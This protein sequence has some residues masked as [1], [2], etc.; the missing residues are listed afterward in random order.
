MVEALRARVAGVLRVGE[1]EVREERALT[2]L[3]LDSLAAV[4]LQHALEVGGVEVAIDELLDGMTFGELVERLERQ[5]KAKEEKALGEEDLRGARDG[6][7]TSDLVTHGQ[8]ALWFLERVAPG[9][10][11]YH[12]AAAARVRG[13]LDAAALRRAF[14]A[15]VARH[16]A[17]RTVYPEVEGEPRAWVLAEGGLDFAEED[18]AGWSDGQALAWLGAEAY[19]AFDLER[20]PVVRVRL[21]QRDSGEPMLLFAVHHIAADFWSLAVALRDLG[22]LYRAERSGTRAGLPPAP[23]FQAQA[24]REAARLAGDMEEAWR[25][26]RET[27][28]GELPVLDLPADRPRPPAQT[29]RGGAVALRLSRGQIDAFR[30]AARRAETTLFTQ[31]F[32]VFSALLS[33]VTGQRDLVLGTPTSGRDGAGGA[34]LAA[35]VGYF[36]NPVPLRLDLSGDPTF[37]ELF[38]RVRRAVLGAFA[39]AALPFPLLAERL[40]PARD[41][42]RTPIFQ[43]MLTLLSGERLGQPGLAGFALSEPAEP[44]ALGDLTLEPL[45]LPERR[46]Q[47]GLALNLAELS[48]G[49]LAVFEHDADL[50]DRTTIARLA[51]WWERLAAGA[52]ADPALPLSA[53]PLLAPAER[54]QLAVEWNDTEPAPAPPALAHDLVFAQAARTPDAVAVAFSSPTDAGEARLTYAELAARAAALA[55]RLRAR[56]I[57]AERP[58]ALCLPRDAEMVVAVLAILAAGGAYLPLDSALPDGRLA[59]VLAEARP[60]LLL[61]RASLA[62][63]LGAFAGCAVATLEELAAGGDPTALVSPAPGD[64]SPASLAYLIYTSGSTGVPK[65][66]AVTHR[67]AVARLRWDGEILSAADLAGLLAGTSAG[68]DISVFELLA[69]LA[70]GGR[71]IVAADTLA[72]PRLPCAGEVTLVSTVPQ[73]LAELVGGGGLPASVRAVTVGGEALP[74][75][76]AQTVLEAVRRSGAARLLNLYGPSEDTIDSTCASIADGGEGAPPIGRPIAGTRAHLLDADGALA[77]LGAVGEIHLG[78]AG[79][80]RGYLHRPDLTAESFRPDP[81]GVDATGARLYATGDLARRRPGGELEYLGRRD[82]QVKVRGVRIELAEVEAALAAHPAVRGAAVVAARAPGSRPGSQE[83]RLV[84][85]VALD[86][87]QPPASPSDLRAF[88]RARLAEPMIPAGLVLLPELPRTPNGKIDRLALARRGWSPEASGGGAPRGP[89]AFL[90]AGLWSEMLGLPAEDLGEA[91]DFFALGGHSLAAVRLASRVRERFGVEVPLASLLAAPTLGGVAASVDRALAGGAPPPPS[92]PVARAAGGAAPLTPAQRRLWFLARL[93]PESAAYHLPAGVRLAGPLDVPALA[94][95][96][97]EI[98]RRHEALRTAIDTGDAGDAGD[99]IDADDTRSDP[100]VDSPSDPIARVLPAG[101]LTL[102]LADLGGLG[103]EPARRELTRLARDEARRPFDLARGPL[104]RFRLL[105]LG[106]AEHAL[107][108]TFHHLVSDGASLAIFQR[109]LGSLYAAFA[110]G[111]PSP[112]AE[113]AA[114]PGDY[115]LWRAQWAAR[116]EAEETA[117]ARFRERLAGAPRELPLPFDRAPRASGD[118]GAAMRAGLAERALSPAAAAALSGLAR[119]AGAT[120][121]MVLAAAASAL[122]G[123]FCGVDDLVL[124]TPVDERRRPELAGTFGLLVNTVPLRVELAGD[125][126]AGEL[127]GRLRREVL[128]A[129][130]HQD[131]PFERL[132]EELAPGRGSGRMPLVQATVT[133][134]PPPLAADLP[135]LAL[136]LLPR[137]PTEAKLDLAISLTEPG[138]GPGAAWNASIEYPAAR[139]DRTTIARLLSGLDA[140]LA[141]MAESGARLSALSPLSPA[142]RQQAHR[143]W[144]DTDPNRDRG[145]LA[146]SFLA[147]ARRQPEAPAVACGGIEISYGELARRAAAVALRLRQLDVGPEAVVGLATERSAERIVGLL[148]IVLAG[149]AYLPLDPAY[150]DERLALMVADAGARAVVAHGGLWREAIA[151]GVAVVEVTGLGEAA[152]A[153]DLAAFSPPPVVAESLACI[154]YT[155]GSTGRPKG[156]AV[157]Q[158]AVLRLVEGADYVRLSPADRVAHLSTLSFD[159]ASFEIWGALLSGARLTMPPAGALS[160]LSIEA[161]GRFVRESGTTVLWLTAGLFRQVVEGGLDDLQGVRQL[162]AG[163]DALSAPHVERALRALPGCRLIDGYGPTENGTFSCCHGMAGPQRFAG[164]VPIGR[165]IAGSRAAVL[166]AGLAEVPIGG[167]G[168]LCVGGEGLARGYWRDPART[169]ERFVPDPAGGEPGARLYRT[170]DRARSLPDG[171]LDFLGRLDRQV[172]VRGF[173]VE[174]GEV[175]AALAAHPEV[176]GAAVEALADPA[177]ERRLVAYVVGDGE[178]ARP[179]TAAPALR[180]F[181]RA[182]L[183]EHAVPSLFVPL[184]ELPLTPQGKVDRRALPAPEAAVAS[185]SIA[186]AATPPAN[187]IAELIATVF[188]EVLGVERVGEGDDFFALGGH[189]L[190]ATRAVSRLSAA[191]GVE[192][193]LADLFAAP[194]PAALAARLAGAGRAAAPPIAR[195]GS[196]GEAPLSFSQERL[197]FL[198]QLQPGSPLY[199]IFGAVRLSGELDVAALAAA[200]AEIVRRHEALRT[201]FLE[202]DGAPVEVVDPPPVAVPLPVVDL[203]G[204]AGPEAAARQLTA[205]ETAARELTDLAAL[206]PFDLARG[207]L[208]RLTLLALGGGEHR[209][210]F[211]LHHIA[212]DGWSIELLL[213]EVRALYAALRA[214]R[215]SPLPPLPVQYRDYAR[216]QRAWLAGE[217]LAAELASWRAALAGAPEALELPADRPRPPLQSHRGGEISLDLPAPEAA[218]LDR[219]GRRFGATRFMVLLAGFA[220]LLARSSGQEE[221][222]VGTPIANRAR[223]ETERLIGFFV[224]TLAL[225]VSLARGAAGEPSGGEVLARVRAAALAAYAHQDLPFERLVDELAPRRDLARHPVFQALL[226]LEPPLVEAG[227]LHG[228]ALERLPTAGR[229]A[230]FDLTLTARSPGRDGGLRLAF[231]YARDLF[232]A[233]TIRRLGGH[234]GAL[235]AGLAADPAAPMADLPLLAP[236]E[237]HQLRREWNDTARSWD[238]ATPVHALFASQARIRPDAVA[239]AMEERAV[240]YGELDRRSRSLARR[241]RARGAGPERTVAVALPR[242]PDLI[243]ALLGTLRAGAAYLPLNAR[244]PRERLARILAESAPAALV[245]R[246]ELLA[247]LPAI[248]VPIVRLSGEGEPDLAAEPPLP[249]G[250][251]PDLV[252]DIAPHIAPDIANVEPE[253]AAYVLYT[254]GSTGEPKGAIVEHR[255]FANLVRQA[256]SAFASRPGEVGVSWTPATFDVSLLEWAAMLASGGRIELVAEERALDVPYLLE[257]MRGAT[258]AHFVPG[259]AREVVQAIAEGGASDGWEPL[260]CVLVGGESLGADLL[261]ALGR[262]FPHAAIH[263]IYGP[264]E[265]AVFCTRRRTA[266]GAA[267]RGDDVGRPIGNAEIHL[268]DRRGRPVPIGVAGEIWIGGAGVGR[269]YLRRPAWTAERYAPL[270]GGGEGRFFRTGDLGRYLADGEIEFLGR[271]DQQVKIRGHRIEPGEV[272]AALARHPAVLEVAVAA[273][274]E[275]SARRL[276]AY[277]VPRGGLAPVPPAEL[278]PELRAAAAERLPDSMLPE[279]YVLLDRLPRSAHGKLDRRALPAPA[280]PSPSAGAPPA[281]DLERRIAAVWEELLGAAPGV[282]DNFFE[283]GG[284]SLLVVRLRSR[285]E[286]ELG[287]DIPVVLLFQHPT[288]AALASRLEREVALAPAALAAAEARTGGRR[289][290]LARLRGARREVAR[291]PGI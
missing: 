95:A 223:L 196:A 202:R 284:N 106:S 29:Y 273:R 169:A 290:A 229:T 119:E 213:G 228:L 227:D 122:L 163:G 72:L 287:R 69:P 259:L 89:V 131:L 113:P 207:P 46:A 246:D 170:G 201:R 193:P 145:S 68:F 23:G 253:N 257:V 144:N 237:A 291:A 281:T 219:L 7:R 19:R 102:P 63:R 154:L 146:A 84:G 47:L 268:L 165:P 221:V 104:A 55:R 236:A 79:L 260:R 31:I 27:L 98:V 183:P 203:S 22:E 210:L 245:S 9:N 49:A 34:D 112:L 152:E 16:E 50:F 117:L 270:A 129:L 74:A 48:S 2:G 61:T 211:A 184:P 182:G 266:A 168:E 262:A 82:G 115:A 161:L 101:R 57:G 249:A 28:A 116:R 120:R 171:R 215:P 153:A 12:I 6:G 280:A 127:V 67:S 36:V 218:A 59:A 158:R 244:H 178:L 91:D 86:E 204:L 24:A 248:P 167:A 191:L 231:E 173:R 140:L 132:V 162:L 92:P 238:L 181:L 141:G 26:W 189:S 33:R 58:V 107:L 105:R 1:G 160:P 93:A 41:P 200:F 235:L 282:R 206:R 128:A 194:T 209:L 39:H 151:P 90:L 174:P 164:A 77:P 285:L 94:A 279:A 190:L 157:P 156:V 175:E 208:L 232:D 142:E 40:Q 17:L 30:D 103:A 186:A 261:A 110:A 118:E 241:L 275:G 44:V 271:A 258:V 286:R 247:W 288:V 88:L 180:R 197:W 150:P 71:V 83:T 264:T 276:V 205:R 139:F 4:E 66:V 195:G 136:S 243:V 62:T 155:S 76:L 199:N 251:A 45:A 225:R 65:G 220:A 172:K 212:G 192:V 130:A 226:S 133:L 97:G 73:V 43:T 60:A 267:G 222:V 85:Y 256:L 283:M 166:G 111:W 272:E 159:A 53:L 143:E 11:A 230:K 109:E 233:T 20:G 177:G 42:S 80:A 108:A 81:F 217:T 114:Q 37:A 187:P 135:G 126:A 32:A 224:N 99:A 147:V 216:W 14:D 269:G 78:G 137:E 176:R 214:G 123:R 254:S 52:L 149:G 15:L 21:L 278:I 5:G 134:D 25:Y 75:A 35:A 252:P 263:N 56:G 185:L 51:G 70:W 239:V 38:A 10:G 240:T 96:L 148:G 277:V 64:L 8:R 54:H 242:D 100:S 255:S 125:P 13:D 179:E 138:S 289:D 188:A 198:D 124:G 3:G 87:A 121:F 265:A 274:G 234:L 250:T 18:G